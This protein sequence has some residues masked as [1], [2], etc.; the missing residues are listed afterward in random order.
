MSL[1]LAFMHACHDSLVVSSHAS[2]LLA[3]IL[4]ADP[5]HVMALA[6]VRPSP[7]RKWISPACYDYGFTTANITEADTI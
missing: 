1:N 2:G 7:L 3:L 4:E 5:D 6:A